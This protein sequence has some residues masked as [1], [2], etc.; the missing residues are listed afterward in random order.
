MSRGLSGGSAGLAGASRSGGGSWPGS[1]A[2][3]GPS[4]GGSAPPL[5]ALGAWPRLPP[6]YRLL[7][8]RRCRDAGERP[9]SGAAI[10]GWRRWGCAR[11]G[12]A[13]RATALLRY[14]S[15][16][17][18]PSWRGRPARPRVGGEAA[19]RWRCRSRRPPCAQGGE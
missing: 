1:R 10:P 11:P 12:S 5:A 8:W 7:K 9:P 4:A 14:P 15:P 19:A 17:E 18:G 2:S 3:R 13:A 6:F 16:A